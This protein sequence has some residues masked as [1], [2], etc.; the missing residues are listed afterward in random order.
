MAEQVPPTTNK[1]LLKQLSSVFVGLPAP[2]S[3]VSVTHHFDTHLTT[4]TTEQTTASLSE[5]ISAINRALSDVTR[6]QEI[7]QHTI[8][9]CETLI[10]PAASEAEVGDKKSKKRPGGGDDRPCGWDKKLVWT[11]EEVEQWRPDE[12]DGMDGEACMAPK[13]RCDRHQ[14]WQKTMTASLDLEA[15]QLVRRKGDLERQIRLQENQ[16][17]QLKAATK[18]E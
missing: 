4:S 12:D 8:T 2:K 14:G 15:G 18:A 16:L 1:K 17:G 11:D 3:N 9:R 5:Q 10:L 13:R 7:L 6:R